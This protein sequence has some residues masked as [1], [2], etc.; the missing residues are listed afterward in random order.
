MAEPKT[1]YQILELTG[2]PCAYSHFKDEDGEI[3]FAPPYIVYIGAGQDDMAAD[4]TYIWAKNRYQ[5]EYYFTKKDEAAE[6]L[7]EKLL[8]DNKYN[9]TKSDDVYIE[10]ENVFVIYYNV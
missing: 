2:L 3:P 1:I 7:I 5:I 9:Y 8:L 6:A 4:N 10:D